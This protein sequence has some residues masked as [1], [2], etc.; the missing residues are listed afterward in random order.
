M[1]TGRASKPEGRRGSQSRLCEGGRYLG[2]PPNG[3]LPAV[4]ERSEGAVDHN[5]V[6]LSVQET[7]CGTVQGYQ[8]ACAGVIERFDGHIAQYLGDGLLVYFGYPQAH[9]WFSEGFDTPDLLEAK[10]LLDGLA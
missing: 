10:A 9:A 5:H 8:Q 4:R 6:L 1:L 2:I 7:G 3:G